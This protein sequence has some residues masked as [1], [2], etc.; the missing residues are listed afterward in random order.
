MADVHLRLN[1]GNEIVDLPSVCMK[2]GAPATVRKSKKFSWIP[3]W[4]SGFAIIPLLYIILANV[5]TK[6]Q[7]VET[8]FCDEHKTYWWMFPLLT[9]LVVLG[10]LGLGFVAMIG[11]VVVGKNNEDLA[12]LVCIV[13]VAVMLVVGIIAVVMNT[14][15]IRVKEITDHHIHLTGVSEEF[16][17]ALKDMEAR[18]RSAFDRA[19]DYDRGPRRSRQGDDPRYTD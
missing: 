15:R 10:L 2:C 7:R 12:G 4:I 9:W 18:Q 11:V 13:M 5:F 8:T 14:R 17:D 16:A 1:P 3:S 6:R 19:D